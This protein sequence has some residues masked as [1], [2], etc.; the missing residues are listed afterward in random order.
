MV[1]ALLFA[2]GMM[3]WLAAAATP[4]HAARAAE[5][6]APAAAD[7]APEPAP[8]AEPR[9][10]VETS[11]GTFTITLH[12]ARAPKTVEN[13]LRY[14][15][16]GHYDGKAFYRVVPGFVVQTGSYDGAGEYH[17]PAHGPIA[18]ETSSGLSNVWSTVAMARG[19][20]P[21]SGAA[22]WFVNLVDNGAL[23]AK[24]GAAPDTTGYAVFGTVTEGRDVIDRIAR[25][26]M[27]GKGPFGAEYAPKKAVV[28]KRVRVLE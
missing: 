14:V 22:E 3:A 10:V 11:M 1:K 28:I 27:G 21:N 15:R 2:A 20:D 23:D 16:E 8:P 26:E 13:F 24:P 19:A 5:A 17:A 18:L 7:A 25:V 6:A 4:I 9:V 12:P